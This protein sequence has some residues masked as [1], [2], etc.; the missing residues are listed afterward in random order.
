MSAADRTVVLV[1]G[2]NTGLGLATIQ[3]LYA[4][5]E[6]YELIL[7][8]RSASNGENAV[9]EVESGTKGNSATTVWPVQ[10]DLADDKS[11]EAAF[12][13]VKDRV[14]HVDVLVNN[15]GGS[16]SAASFMLASCRVALASLLARAGLTT[17]VLL[18]HNYEEGIQTWRQVLNTTFD[19]N[20]TGTHILSW[21]FAPLLL[22]SPKPTPRLVFISSS[23]GSFSYHEKALFPIDA[24]PDESGWP[25][26]LK[27]LW[28]PAYRVSKA[29]ENMLMREWYRWLGADKQVGLYSPYPIFPLTALRPRLTSRSKSSLSPPA[30]SPPTSAAATSSS[31]A[32]APSPSL[33]AQTLSRAS[34]RASGTR[35]QASSSVLDT[36]TRAVYALGS[37]S[38]MYKNKIATTHS[39]HAVGHSRCSV[40][41]LD[42]RSTMLN[43]ARW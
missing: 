17:G 42:K 35:K 7:G 40:E 33:P 15:A 30:S 23:V 22:A 27:K 26:P 29:A 25:K 37:Q 41:R 12:E 34:S 2:A 6:A 14:G 24:A 28:S 8:S 10:L 9:K 4:A 38:Q 36:S 20:L 21:T 31:R 13:T 5:P 43:P 19:V 18:D 16:A 3:A 1:T 11:I 39:M 32:S